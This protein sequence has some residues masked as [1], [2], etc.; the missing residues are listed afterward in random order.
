MTEKRIKIYYGD[1]GYGYESVFKDYL[2]NAQEVRVEDPYIRKKYQIVNFVR[3]C[4]MLVK[5]GECK[6]LT[7]ITGADDEEQKRENLLAFDHI[8]D[9]LFDQGIEFRFEF[10]NILH[11]RE[12][13]LSNGWNIKMGRGLDYFQSISNNYLQIGANDLD[14]RP[15]LETSFD[16]FRS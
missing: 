10:N 1:V 2:V 13:I 3:F 9:N 6:K 16:I 5:I 4:E 8:A 15:C 11:D 7:L 14:L 12:I